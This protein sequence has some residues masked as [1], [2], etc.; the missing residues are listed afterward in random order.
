METQIHFCPIPGPG[1]SPFR[2]ASSGVGG[3]GPGQVG[4]RI[5]TSEWSSGGKTFHLRRE[6][7]THMA[8]LKNGRGVQTSQEI[9]LQRGS[10]PFPPE[11]MISIPAIFAAS[12][13]GGEE[14]KRSQPAR[15]RYFEMVLT[16]TGGKDGAKKNLPNE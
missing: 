2:R 16:V 7:I 11:T 5:K 9:R 14:T 13:L 12:Y 6:T 3:C 1:G 10:T 15:R 8:Q 4:E